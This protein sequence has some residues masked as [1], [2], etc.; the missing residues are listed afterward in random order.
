MKNQRQFLRKSL[1]CTVSLFDE[2]FKCVGVMVDYSKDGIM[3]SSYQTIQTDKTF[4]FS[5]VD[6]PKYSGNK[7]S[8]KIQVQSVWCAKIDHTQFG[9]GF[10]LLNSDDNAQLMF[11]SYDDS[12]PDNQP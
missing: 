9:T 6:L 5:M 4:T 3:I 11:T 1:N 7:R 10:R 2:D 12:Q 8:G